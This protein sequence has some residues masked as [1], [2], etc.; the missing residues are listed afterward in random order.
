[1]IGPSFLLQILIE[2]ENMADTA[3]QGNTGQ[4]NQ[5]NLLLPCPLLKCLSAS[6]MCRML[7][8]ARCSSFLAPAHHEKAASDLN[9]GILQK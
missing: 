4:A 2:H 3:D 9:K 6:L 1:M 8:P 5:A 7:Q